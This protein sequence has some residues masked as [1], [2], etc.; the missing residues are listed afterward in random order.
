MKYQLEIK[1]PPRNN[2]DAFNRVW[3]RMVVKK[4]PRAFDG[5]SCSYRT[6]DGNACAIGYMLPAR[7]F[8]R[9]N[10]L[11][12]RD[13]IDNSTGAKRWL[14]KVDVH[15]LTCLQC[16]HD[17]SIDSEGSP[18]SLAATKRELRVIAKRYKLKVPKC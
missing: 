5:Y 14:S 7:L 2:Q 6:L 3:R 11:D 13:L 8:K 16:V 12:V 4:Y 9:S 1:T 15:L 10:R 18:Q 17:K